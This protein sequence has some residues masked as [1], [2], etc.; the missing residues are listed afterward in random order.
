MSDFK[1]NLEKDWQK[2]KNDEIISQIRNGQ[3]SVLSI[4]KTNYINPFYIRYIGSRFSFLGENIREKQDSI[5][6]V[7][8]SWKTLF[9]KDKKE[10]SKDELTNYSKLTSKELNEI[11]DWND[12]AQFKLIDSMQNQF[13]KLQNE[14]INKDGQ[15]VIN[16]VPELTTNENYAKFID[17]YKRILS[18][19]SVN[20]EANF[21]KETFEEKFGK[22][23][24][25]YL[26]EYV[27]NQLHQ[28]EYVIR[29][30]ESI[31]IVNSFIGMFGATFSGN[32]IIQFN[33]IKTNLGRL[34]NY[35]SGLNSDLNQEK[36]LFFGNEFTG[37]I[38]NPLP[39]SYPVATLNSDQLVE[40]SLLPKYSLSL[41]ADLEN[42]SKLT[43]FTIDNPPY[44]YLLPD[45]PNNFLVDKSKLFDISAKKLLNQKLSNFHTRLNCELFCIID[46]NNYGI[47]DLGD[48]ASQ[49][50]FE[51]E[52]GGKERRGLLIL[53]NLKTR[54]FYVRYGGGLETSFSEKDAKEIINLMKPILKTGNNLNAFLKAIDL[55]ELKL[56][57]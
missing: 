1:I 55:I 15:Y 30:P 17:S 16:L 40:K 13:N 3:N 36:L 25:L 22:T 31:D 11:Y 41:F 32:S 50:G 45:R 20:K 46:N 23:Y 4:N 57:K 54:K 6:N 24:S 19:I 37:F 53:M 8:A 47:E 7:I 44:E 34:S 2:H 29:N 18:E 39:K 49:Y 26:Y 5:S 48:L 14:L 27:N 21:S 28:S 38:T 42:V 33:A 10:W 52:I 43:E 51:W 12:Y 35:I 9:N 56:S